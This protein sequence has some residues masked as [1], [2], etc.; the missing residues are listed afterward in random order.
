MNYGTVDVTKLVTPRGA[1]LFDRSVIP[2]ADANLLDADFWGDAAHSLNARGGRGSVWRVVAPFG[3]AVLRHYRRGGLP[4]RFI[5]DAYL[6]H[7]QEATRGFAEFR[8][9]AQLYALGLP[10]PRPLAA[11]FVREGLLYRADLMTA[12]IGDAKTLAELGREGITEHRWHELGELLAT[13]HQHGVFHADL[14]AHNIMLDASGKLWLIDFDRGQL[15]T[16][17]QRWQQ[18]NLQRLKRSLDKLQIAGRERGWR[19]LLAS[20]QAA[21]L[22]PSPAGGKWPE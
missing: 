18:A 20:Y 22:S 3:D 7:G 14:N 8:L 21:L 4:G 17:A 2:Q 6:F 10:V 9:L 19:D 11:G 5:R 16:P 13:F 1:I 12:R 15:R